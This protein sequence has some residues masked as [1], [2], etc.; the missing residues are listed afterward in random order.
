MQ[1]SALTLGDLLPMM[2][3]TKPVLWMLLLLS[4]SG[5]AADPD[6][7]RLLYENHCGSCHESSVHIREVQA[8]KSL[9][10]VRAQVVRW[11]EALGL[12]WSAEEVGDVSEYLNVA[13]YHYAEG[14]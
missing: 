7:G 8:A 10:A 5:V 6:R 1:Q 4:A 11:Q 3:R 2:T 14:D 12:Q 13:W 9:E